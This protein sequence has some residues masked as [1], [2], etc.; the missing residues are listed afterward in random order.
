MPNSLTLIVPALNEAPHLARTVFEAEEA[1]SDLIHDY[2]ILIFNDG[3]TDATGQ[4]AAILA[5]QN[6][7][8]R[9]FHH[10]RPRGLGYCYKAGVRHASKEHVLLVPGD[11][12]LRQ[13]SLHAICQQVG[14]TD[15]VLTY[16]LNPEIRPKSRQTISQLF[17]WIVRSASN[18]PVRYFNGPVAHRTHMVKRALEY[19]SDGFTYQAEILVRMIQSGAS[20]VEVGMYLNARPKT[21]AFRLSNVFSVGVGILKLAYRIRCQKNVLSLPS[22]QP[23]QNPVHRLRTYEA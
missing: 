14:H 10:D 8:V 20:Y 18:L 6:P 21:S 22:P 23:V 3:S 11:N 1:M 15:I 5:G 4:I 7:R 9:V 2:E 17:S 13:D 12:E 16:S 19:A